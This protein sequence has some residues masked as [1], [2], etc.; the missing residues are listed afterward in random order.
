MRPLESE[1]RTAE[2]VTL[3]QVDAEPPG[4]RGFCLGLEALEHHAAV[5]GL[6]EA[7][8]QLEAALLAL[9]AIEV[10]HDAHVDR[11]E[12]GLQFGQHRPRVL[13]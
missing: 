13:A 2:Q 7:P 4:G 3:Q 1:R 12:R 10:A 8:Q 6:C 11:H 9:L 5:G